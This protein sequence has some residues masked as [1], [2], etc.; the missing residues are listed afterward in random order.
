MATYSSILE[1]PMDRGDWWAIVRACVLSCFSGD[2]LS[3]TPCTRAHLG[4]LSSMGLQES[5]T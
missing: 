4:K 2:Q 1:N 5:R 3:A